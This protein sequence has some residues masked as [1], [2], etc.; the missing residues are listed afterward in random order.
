MRRLLLPLL[1][2]STSC[3]AT[4]IPE[5]LRGAYTSTISKPGSCTRATVIDPKYPNAP[6]DDGGMVVL[7][8]RIVWYEMNCNKFEISPKSDKVNFAFH[9]S[10]RGE[11]QTWT[12]EM[13]LKPVVVRGRASLLVSEH[14]LEMKATTVDVYERCP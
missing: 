6:Q 8:D 10:C 12:S 7:A 9:A 4:E 14:Y 5:Q 3:L 2:G 11:G 1:I 13:V